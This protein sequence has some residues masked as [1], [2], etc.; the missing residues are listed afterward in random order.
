MTIRILTPS[1]FAQFPDYKQC[2]V[3]TLVDRF[4]GLSIHRGWKI[5]G[6]RYRKEKRQCLVQEFAHSFNSPRGSLAGW[7]ELC[8]FV[9]IEP[10]T[11]ITK[12]K[13]VMPFLRRFTDV[14]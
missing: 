3:H 13:K 14:S 7:Q 2:E 10:S 12:C 9:D 6:K 11:S 5:G 1:Y 4:E 8:E